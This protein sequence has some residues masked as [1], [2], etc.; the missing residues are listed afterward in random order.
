MKIVLNDVCPS[1]YGK[2]RGFYSHAGQSY[3]GNSAA[4]AMSLLVREIEGL[5]TAAD[6]I[7]NMDQATTID[8]SYILSV[9]ATPTATSIENLLAKRGNE[10]GNVIDEQLTKLQNCIED[11]RRSQIIEIHAGVYPILDMQQVSTQ[12]SPSAKVN[13][14]VD[15]KLKVS[16]A[17]IAL[18]I[19]AEVA[20]VYEDR[21][22]REALIAAGSLALGREPCKSYNGWGI[23]SDWGMACQTGTG[24]SG[25]QVGRISQEH[26]VLT[27]DSSAGHDTKPSSV[28]APPNTE[29]LSVG[30]KVRIWPNHAC[31][32][33]AGFGWYLV[34]DSSL[35]KGRRDE[36]VDVWVRCRGW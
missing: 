35:P 13:N 18:T 25:W 7:N 29:D 5:K 30:Q 17:D 28:T 12:A 27:K 15:T 3:G 26:G 31:I 34:V 8:K 21:E 33:G 36:V 11:T 20:S 1:D 16:T 32:A 22:N 24:L 19:L 6:I 14:L 23:V 10:E 4:A 9:G 2:L